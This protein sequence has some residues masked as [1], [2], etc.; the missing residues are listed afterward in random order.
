M[1]S[2]TAVKESMTS[3]PALTAPGQTAEPA[4]I[5]RIEIAKR[6]MDFVKK[7]PVTSSFHPSQL[8][9]W[10]RILSEIAAGNTRPAS[11]SARGARRG[12]RPLNLN[13]HD[14]GPFSGGSLRHCAAELARHE[15]R[16]DRIEEEQGAKDRGLHHDAL[17]ALDAREDRLG[18][19]VGRQRPHDQ[20]I[21][22]GHVLA[23]SRIVLPI[24]SLDHAEHHERD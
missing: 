9:C 11:M 1:Q 8:C 2:G 17:S 13:V 18:C 19:L 20:R 5:A 10:P 24:G 4:A 14:F 22:G 12:L 21:P 16:R 6:T 7:A 23:A 15:P 3:S